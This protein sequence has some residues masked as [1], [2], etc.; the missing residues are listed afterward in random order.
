MLFFVVDFLMA[1]M[2]NEEEKVS[3]NHLRDGNIEPAHAI[4]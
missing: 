2:V 3:N 1:L 4:G